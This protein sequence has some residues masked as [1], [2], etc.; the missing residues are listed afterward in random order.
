MSALLF[1]TRRIPLKRGPGR[2]NSD[3]DGC[4]NLPRHCEQMVCV[5]GD[6]PNVLLMDPS[7][8]KTSSELSGHLDF[9]FAAAW[10]PNGYVLATGNQDTTTR[11]WDIRYPGSAFA[12]L[13]GRI[14][15][16]SAQCMH[17]ST[18]PKIQWPS[19]LHISRMC[20]E[21]RLPTDPLIALQQRW[22]IP[23]HGGAGR[24]RS[25][26]RCRLRL[27]QVPRDRPLWRDRWLLLQP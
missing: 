11:L 24:L 27:Q 13:Q 21:V 22:A 18:T 23:R 7:T 14:C 8:G 9:S 19:S 12:T 1:R 6:N 25:R 26:L 20:P 5:V 2:P 3:T 16:V 15:A 4:C 17:S 10:H